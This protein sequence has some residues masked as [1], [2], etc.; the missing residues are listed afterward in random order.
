MQHPF[1]SF[2]FG[3]LLHF[4]ARH[5]SGRWLFAGHQPKDRALRAVQKTTYLTPCSYSYSILDPQSNLKIRPTWA[6]SCHKHWSVPRISLPIPTSSSLCAFFV[7]CF[8]KVPRQS[9]SEQFSWHM[10]SHAKWFHW[11]LAPNLTHILRWH[12]HEVC[13]QRPE[14]EHRKLCKAIC[15]ERMRCCAL[16]KFDT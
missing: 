11:I 15:T 2:H 16:T 7:M 9:A 12:R 1:I 3:G 4:Q 5:G 14:P 10:K 6:K 13:V 8:D